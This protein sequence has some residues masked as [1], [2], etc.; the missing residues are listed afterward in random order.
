MD[1]AELNV[2]I[3]KCRKCRLWKEAK[4]VVPGEGPLNAKVMLI[5]QNPGA[6]EAE[7][8]RPFVGR[9]GKFLNKVLS[10]NGIDRKEVYITNIVKHLTPQNRVPLP[11]EVAACV[12]YLVAQV[13]LI[14]PKIVV[15]MG[16]VAWQA[17]RVAGV[18]YVE[19]VHPSAAM[20]FTKMRNRFLQD[21]AAL[22][23]EVSA[24]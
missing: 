24:V 15:L 3:L 19:T 6:E 4:N 18:R 10:A 17:H 2:E 16:K 21:F 23:D 13:E 20:R 14:K 12:P 1:A 8:G 9:A 5:G 7:V 22:R 11:D